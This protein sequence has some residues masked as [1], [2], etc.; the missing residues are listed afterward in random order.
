MRARGD[1]TARRLD[2]SIRVRIELSRPFEPVYGTNGAPAGIFAGCDG[3]RG[4]MAGKSR[5]R[6]KIGR[7]ASTA[8]KSV[9]KRDFLAAS[10]FRP[11]IAQIVPREESFPCSRDEL[12]RVG[13]RADP[14]KT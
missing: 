14:A 1:E 11:R 4:R 2:R 10:A 5:S 6:P 9:T 8:G 13:L 3:H 7:G 12:S